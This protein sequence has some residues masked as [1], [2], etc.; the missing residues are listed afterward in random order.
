MNCWIRNRSKPRSSGPGRRRHARRRSCTRRRRGEPACRRRRR[1]RPA[2]AARTC[3]SPARPAASPAC[4][5][6]SLKSR[7]II[8]V[9]PSTEKNPHDTTRVRNSS[10]VC[11][12]AEADRA[13]GVGGVPHESRLLLGEREVVGHREAKLER[14]RVGVDAHEVLG[15]RVR[16]R[17]QH[18]R[19]DR[20]EDRGGGADADADGDDDRQRQHGR[21][22]QAAQTDAKVLREILEYQ[23]AL[24]LVFLL[25]ILPPAILAASPRD[26]R[27]AASPRALRRPRVM[28]PASRARRSASRDARS[29]L[30]RRPPSPSGAAGTRTASSGSRRPIV[31]TLPAAPR[32]PPHVTAP[33]RGLF[34]QPLPARRASACRSAPGGCFR[35]AP[36]RH[37]PV[38][39]VQAVQRLIQGR[40]LD[41]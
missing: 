27:T 10:A 12:V 24:H 19:V 16:Q 6:A 15:L 18:R 36:T 26:R 39:P 5:P 9:M 35:T 38:L 21:A 7:P 30:R 13:I 33:V 41:R 25:F 2:A 17:P 29:T 37:R 40:V 1:G 22:Q 28:P 31:Q 34:A 14:R 3:S 20:A 23:R 4:R 8:G 11:A 32:R